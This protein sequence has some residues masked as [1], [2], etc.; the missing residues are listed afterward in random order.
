MRSLVEALP[1]LAR[2]QG[3]V[4]AV[5]DR[6]G[7]T[8]RFLAWS[9][10]YAEINRVAEALSGLPRGEVHAWA[11]PAGSR[12]LVIDL[13]L[14]HLGVVGALDA[15]G[16]HV[17]TEAAYDEL[18]QTRGALGRLVRLATELRPRDPAVE[19]AGR[20]LDHGAVIELA[21]RV[22]GAFGV[23]APESVL[24]SASGAAEQAV[25]WGALVG[26]YG[27][28]AGAGDLLASVQPA[29]WVCTP[30]QLDAVGLSR[31]RAGALGS[32]LRGVGRAGELVG[33][34][35]R[36]VYVEGAI[37]ASADALR[38]RGIEVTPWVA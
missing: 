31:S 9:E 32:V 15:P 24:V 7:A 37:P 13:A 12:R 38:D 30:A 26:G 35:L 19:R 22:A 8:W 4:C 17:Y 5:R 16:A 23:A 14:L 6:S 11:A 10:L 33:G 18:V 27:V 28:V 1:D 21:K 20:R 25:G 3:A 36:K 34:N 2:D 29:V